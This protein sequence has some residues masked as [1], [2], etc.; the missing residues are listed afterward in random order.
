MLLLG[1]WTN[2]KKAVVSYTTLSEK[3]LNDAATSFR[4]HCKAKYIENLFEKLFWWRFYH[5]L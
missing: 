1:N 4:R 2:K 3:K 5:T